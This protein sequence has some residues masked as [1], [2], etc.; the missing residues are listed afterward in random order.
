MIVTMIKDTEN[1]K[2]EHKQL[3]TIYTLSK[4]SLQGKAEEM[5]YPLL[6]FL[7]YDKSNVYIMLFFHLLF[8][9]SLVCNVDAP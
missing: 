3:R 1:N 2:I 4:K 6:F 7:R 9:G 8:L 5:E